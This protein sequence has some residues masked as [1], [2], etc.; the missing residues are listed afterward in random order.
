MRV[1]TR[2]HGGEYSDDM[3][4]ALRVTD[5]RERVALYRPITEDGKVVDSRGF[6]ME[7]PESDLKLP[8]DEATVAGRDPEPAAGFGG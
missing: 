2:E 5:Q 4:Q 6:C 3:P 8:A 1:E 7:A